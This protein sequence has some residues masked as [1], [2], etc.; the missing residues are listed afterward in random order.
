[1][2]SEVRCFKCGKSTW[3]G[4]GDHVEYA[5][6]NVKLEDRCKCFEKDPAI[7]DVPN[8]ICKS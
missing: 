3:S 1:M 8:D 6:R 5:L 7:V 2:C 4:C